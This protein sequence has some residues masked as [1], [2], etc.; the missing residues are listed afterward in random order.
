[1][2]NKVKRSWKDIKLYQL[3]EIDSLGEIEDL[4][5]KMINYLSILLDKDPMDIQNKM[6]INEL[7]IEFES[8]SFLNK[9]PEPKCIPMI[10]SNGNRYGLIQ[11]KDLSLGQ[12]SDI[13]EYVNDGLIKNAHKILSVLYLP[14]I[15]YNFINNKYKISE[16]E[17]DVKR[18]NDMLNLTMDVLYP[19]ILFFYHI[20]KTYL[21]D[22]TYCSGQMKH[23]METMKR[24]IINQLNPVNN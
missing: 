18:E 16:Y 13:E 22:L 4:E 7:V 19:S 6:P 1:M 9:L 11:F 8:W 2:G 14:I 5:K 17:P 21:E 12:I 23:L 10:R 3:Q 15:S 24:E 20:V